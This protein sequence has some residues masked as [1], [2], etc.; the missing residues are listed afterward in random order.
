MLS[1]CAL[2]YKISLGLVS[3]NDIKYKLN[4]YFTRDGPFYNSQKLKEQT[5]ASSQM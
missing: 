4:T 1:L 3:K 2:L 5:L